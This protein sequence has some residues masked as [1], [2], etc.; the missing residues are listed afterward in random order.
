MNQNESDVFSMVLLGI[1]WRLAPGF[2]CPKAA[3][4]L[5]SVWRLDP[6]DL[7]PCFELDVSDVSGK[8]ASCKFL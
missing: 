3:L 6:K 7:A 5:D 8:Y 2:A 1:S 4:E